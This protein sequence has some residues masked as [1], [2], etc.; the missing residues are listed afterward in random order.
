M[1]RSGLILFLLFFIQ[2]SHAANIGSCAV[3]TQTGPA[4]TAVAADANKCIVMNNAASNT[5]TV[6][7]NASVPY[8]MGTRLIVQQ[9]GAGLTTLAGGIGVTFTNSGGAF[10]P[11]TTGAQFGMIVLRKI[12]TNT[13]NV[14]TSIAQILLPGGALN[15]DIVL[16]AGQPTGILISSGNFAATR[17]GGVGTELCQA[18]TG[19]WWDDTETMGA[20]GDTIFC[21]GIGSPVMELLNEDP[22]I[23]S[24]GQMYVVGSDG[25]HSGI[26]E[27]T[28]GTTS[29]PVGDGTVAECGGVS[30]G[31][32]NFVFGDGSNNT[33]FQD[34]VT[35]GIPAI[36]IGNAAH[37]TSSLNLISGSASPPTV[38]G[39]QIAAVRTAT[40]ASLGGSALVAGACTTGT[41]TVTGATVGMD[42]HAT[43]ST[44]PGDG[45]EW[46]AY[47]SAANTVTV[48]ICAIVALTP[49]ASVYNV[50]V[51]Q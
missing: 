19:L 25:L 18:G 14:D 3:N 29:C 28:A 46:A 9:G 36:K 6:P 32:P 23:N 50:R 15:G 34:V 13:W 20:N 39:V 12:A 37:T 35:G 16:S 48:K 40:T 42:A 49:T 10:N 27:A 44:Y 8:S 38:N 11:F 24:F 43:P 5:F 31:A 51:I 2:V 33:I 21:S 45:S 17:G 4:Y 47:V 26:F 30:V 1:G 22:T 41:V 7:P